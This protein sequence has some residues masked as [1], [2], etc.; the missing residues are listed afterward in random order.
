MKLEYEFRIRS[1]I[2]KVRAFVEDAEANVILETVTNAYNL[3]EDYLNKNMEGF[4]LYGKLV[5]FINVSE[6][7][8]D[9][10]Y[11]IWLGNKKITDTSKYDE[12]LGKL[13][14][15]AYNDLGWEA[16]NED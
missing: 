14:E 12:Q 4:E 16:E 3:M 1:A 2:D 13:L 11:E 10:D 8:V 15:V 6:E 9:V 5:P 7:R